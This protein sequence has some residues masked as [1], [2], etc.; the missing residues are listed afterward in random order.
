[1]IRPLKNGL[2]SVRDANSANSQH[3]VPQAATRVIGVGNDIRG[4]DGVGLWIAQRLKAANLP[5]SRIETKTGA[6][7]ALIDSWQPT[8]SIILMDAIY[9]GACASPGEIYRI[10]ARRQMIPVG[11]SGP[12]THRLGVAQAVEL[13][14]AL[15]RLPRHFILYGIVGQCF[16]FG[17]PLTPMV[18]KSAGRVARM[19]IDEI[20][21]F[22]G[23]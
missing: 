17:S 11:F 3:P 6:A 18:R 7:A 5:G 13:A 15:G 1:M 22:S 8:D 4:D 20:S 10:D 12:F 23:T 19:V 14:R 9:S 16:D 2:T 21:R